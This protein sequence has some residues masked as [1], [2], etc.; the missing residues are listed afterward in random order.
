VAVHDLGDLAVGTAVA[1]AACGDLGD[2]G[3]QLG[4]VLVIVHVQVVPRREGQLIEVLDVGHVRVFVVG[5]A[6][7]PGDAG[8][9]LHGH[10]IGQ[11][12]KYVVELV[13]G[14]AVEAAL[15]GAQGGLGLGA[16][17]R[18]NHDMDTTDG[19][20]AHP[21]GFD[22]GV[23]GRGRGLVDHHVGLEGLEVVGDHLVRGHVLGLTVHEHQVMAAG[24]Q[25]ADGLGEV[26]GMALDAPPG[27]GKPTGGLGEVLAEHG[28][29]YG[30]AHGVTGSLR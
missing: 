3:E 1:A 17:V 7:H 29:K 13:A 24:L 30:D 26:V 2:E 11:V 10:A 21:G 19:F 5:L 16:H 4:A 12:A 22:V 25:H 18:A 23:D 27:A 28:V 9:V 15:G 8:A 14:D 6:V 20:L